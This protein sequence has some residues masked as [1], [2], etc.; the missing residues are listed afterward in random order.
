MD[1]DVGKLNE[2]LE[3]A[4]FH[5]N[6]WS[7]LPPDI[8]D[9]IRQLNTYT[10]SERRTLILRKTERSAF[11]RRFPDMVQNLVFIEE[12]ERYIADYVYGNFTQAETANKMLEAWT[13]ASI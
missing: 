11:E 13:A 9:K 10:R 12:D 1:Y 8:V 3:S 6:G 7:H 2:L 4:L 5:I